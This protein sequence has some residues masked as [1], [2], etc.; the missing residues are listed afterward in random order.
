[1]PEQIDKYKDRFLK[2]AREFLPSFDEGRLCPDQYIGNIRVVRGKSTTNPD[3]NPLNTDFRLRADLD[4][5]KRTDQPII[6]LVTESPH[7]SEY[8]GDSPRPVAGNG[9][10]DAGRAIRELFNEAC[11][12]HNFQYD[13]DYQLVVMNAIRYQCSLG[14]KTIKFRDKVFRASWTDFGSFDFEA[15][16]RNIYKSG[17]LVINACTAGKDKR[18]RLR[19]MVKE[20]IEKVAGHT[21][22]EIEH[23]CSWGRT[24]NK[25]RKSGYLPN[26]GWKNK[27]AS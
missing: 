26:Y 7:K 23:P 13:G 25:A 24:Y 3:P 12:L 14:A 4:C 17:D 11:S 16:L 10:G 21:T 19:E 1:M 27:R 8:M 9:D 20:M 5:F 18:K 15:R 6:I 2:I 22:M